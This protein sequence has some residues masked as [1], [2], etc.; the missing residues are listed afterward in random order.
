[1]NIEKFCAVENSRYELSRVF[2]VGGYKYAL[3]GR[4]GVRIKSEEAETEG[5][6]PNVVDA[7]LADKYREVSPLKISMPD[8]AKSSCEM[9]TNGKRKYDYR[10][11]V[12][13][14]GS[15]DCKCGCNVRH[16]CSECGGNGG[17]YTKAMTCQFCNGTQERYKDVE[18]EGMNYKGHYIAL[19]SRELPDLT[20]VGITEEGCLKMTFKGGE[21][22][23][24]P[25]INHN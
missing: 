7:L 1:M 5:N 20:V 23:L 4:M 22:F 8:I 15:G 9:C 19:A 13:C 25:F 24:M 18:I 11:C 10:D 3:D 12:S 21:C 16:E 2:V 17:M 14:H 6:F